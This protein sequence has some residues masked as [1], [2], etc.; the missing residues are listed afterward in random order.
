VI[1]TFLL[2]PLSTPSQEAPGSPEFEAASIKPAKPGDDRGPTFNFTPG[3]GL[4]VT[5]GTLK[6]LI[7][8]AYDM[9]DFQ[10]SGGPAWLDSARYDLIAKSAPDSAETP[11]STSPS[12]SPNRTAETRTRL[13]ILLAQRFQLRIRRDTRELPL[14][15]LAQGKNGSRLLPSDGSS[16]AAEGAP[17]GVQR[18]CG[19]MTGTKTSMANLAVMLERQLDR[20]VEDR[21]GLS[22]KYTFHIEW[23]PDAGP[24]PVPPDAANTGAPIRSPEHPSIFTALQEQLGLKLESAK[25]PVEVIVVDRAE[26]P[27]DN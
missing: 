24:C 14:Y 11:I 26:K 27:G 23:T 2:M 21:T 5:N 6:G 9:R 17:A 15:L 4:T 16:T 3:G 25:G 8:A 13:Q 20:P 19:Q 7:E 1:L 12:A 18:S 10:I 22:G